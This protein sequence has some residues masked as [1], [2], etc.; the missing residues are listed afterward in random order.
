MT[1]NQD[2][3]GLFIAFE[4]L[5]GSGSDYHAAALARFLTREGYRVALRHEPTN[6]MIGGLIRARLAGEWMIAPETLQL[7]FTADRA[8][9]LRTAI[10][11]ALEAGKVVICDR[12][13][14]SAL[15]YNVVL[16]NDPEWLKGLNARF[17]WPDLTFLVQ[18]NPTL[19]ARRVKEARLEL[20]LTRETKKLKQVW[21]AYESLAPEY[22]GVTRIDGERDDVAIMDEL[23]E[24]TRR[25]LAERKR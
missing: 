19:A 25:A 7:L 6:S 2:H 17:I 18:V 10:L 20:D 24:I 13:I 3:A 21:G 1:N 8:E 22:P 12:Y 16:V 11:P 14:L 23:I 15:A 5:D 4:G 9:H